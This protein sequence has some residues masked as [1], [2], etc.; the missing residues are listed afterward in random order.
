MQGGQSGVELSAWTAGQMLVDEFV[1]TTVTLGNHKLT[2]YAG[3][4]VMR[5]IG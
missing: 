4:T 5:F 2:Q 1:G 3:G